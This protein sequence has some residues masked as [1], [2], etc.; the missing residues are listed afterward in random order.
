MK[1]TPQ[2]VEALRAEYSVFTPERPFVA[3]KWAERVLREHGLWDDS[4]M[5][6][7]QPVPDT[8]HDA[9]KRR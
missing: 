3:S 5:I 9:Y 7:Q 2:Q 6:V 1:M 4:R 8:S